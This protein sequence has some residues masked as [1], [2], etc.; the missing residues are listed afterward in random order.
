[1][2]R[3]LDDRDFPREADVED[4]KGDSVIKVPWPP[5]VSIHP[6]SI[7]FCK[8]CPKK[9]GSRDITWLL[10]GV[11]KAIDVKK[12]FKNL[13]ANKKDSILCG[14]EIRAPAVTP[15][16]IAIRACSLSRIGSVL[17]I[18]GVIR[19]DARH[20]P[21]SSV[22]ND[23]LNIGAIIKILILGWKFFPGLLLREAQTVFVIKR[24]VYI[25]VKDVANIKK[26]VKRYDVGWNIRNS[27]IRSLE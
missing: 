24:T 8:E 12:W 10:M 23:K 9:I 7:F 18:S 15:V 13:F 16:V 3:T 11:A 21:I 4:L 1:M 19:V 17:S 6:L 26:T 2:T 20:E 5:R 27:I 25:D 22:A 14:T